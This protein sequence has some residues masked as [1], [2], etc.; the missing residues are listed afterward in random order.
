MQMSVLLRR[1]DE[2]RGLGIRLP[3]GVL[4][5]GEPG[6]GKTVMAEALIAESGL[7]CVRVTGENAEDD[8]PAVRL[9]RCAAEA[10]EQAPCILFIDEL[11]KL[12]CLMDD[13][14]TLSGGSA[15]GMLLHLMDKLRDTGVTVLSAPNDERLANHAFSRSGRFDR[16]IRIAMPSE[17]DRRE[18][19]RHYAASLPMAPRIDYDLLARESI[20]MTGADLE[21][22]LNEAGLRAF[23]AGHRRIRQTDVEGAFE[24]LR[25]RGD[26]RDNTLSPEKTRVVAAHESGHTLITLLLDSDALAGVTIRPVGDAQGHTTNAPDT[27]VLCTLSDILDRMTMLAGG[28]AAERLMFPDE[29]Y[30]GSSDDLGKA[31]QMAECL[32]REEG[33]FGPEYLCPR[34]NGPFDIRDESDARLSRREARV[35]ALLEE[36]SERAARLL[37][38]NRETLERLTAELAAREALTREDVLAL[39][40]GVTLRVPDAPAPCRPDA[41]SA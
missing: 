30:L 39:T 4:L 5:V 29:V 9:T 32:L 2:L 37:A 18:I 38:A 41:R 26:S 40:E 28:R 10:R 8:P 22:T 33:V 36:A 15:P 13:G 17:N 6:V 16:V 12:L 23:S 24:S 11:D 3:R 7:P 20:G 1:S 31:W 34:G 27:M 19:L 14:V 35:T 21:S 25:F